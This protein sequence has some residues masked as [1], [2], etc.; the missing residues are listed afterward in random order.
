MEPLLLIHNLS[1]A[2]QQMDDVEG[3]VA[4]LE[5]II[6]VAGLVEAVQLLALCLP[7]QWLTCFSPTP[8]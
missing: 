5:D 4:A 8:A 7:C 3:F 6:S 1:P 2:A